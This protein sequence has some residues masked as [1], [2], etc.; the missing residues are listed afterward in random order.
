MKLG[1]ILTAGGYGKRVGNPI[2]KQFHLIKGKAIFIHSLQNLV[3]SIKFNS[4]VITYPVE[5]KKLMFDILI[6]NDFFD[7]EIIEGGKERFQSVWNALRSP[8]IQNTD[9]VFVH[10]AVRPFVRKDLVNRLYENV[11]KHKAVVPG[12]LVKDTLKEIDHDGFVS[13][14]ISRTNIVAIQTP[15]AFSTS[16]LISAYEKAIS[17][18]F[19]FTDEA[20]F[21][22]YFGHKVKVVEG[23]ENNIK[24]TTPQDLLYAE[25]IIST[26]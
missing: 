11:I 23:D 2:P 4:V 25:F 14:T 24:I 9:F 22:E 20:G 7:I 18:G 19:S 15:Q 5:Y 17:E 16:L 12:I 21:V 3:N 1:L 8:Q 13:K 26:L 10:D 6:K